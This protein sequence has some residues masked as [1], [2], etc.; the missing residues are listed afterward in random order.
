MLQAQFSSGSGPLLL[1]RSVDGAAPTPWG[2]KNDEPQ[3]ERISSISLVRPDGR[4][5]VMKP[6]L[7]G[8]RTPRISRRA[9]SNARALSGSESSQRPG[10]W[11]HQPGRWSRHRRRRT[12]SA[13][14]LRRNAALLADLY[15]IKCDWTLPISHGA[16]ADGD[17]PALV[18]QAVLS[19]I[20]A[21]STGEQIA[22]ARCRRFSTGRT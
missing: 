13:Q 9:P 16:L 18:F 1:R 8:G 3:G 2:S 10:H 19:T 22:Q 14:P 15:M 6:S 4:L 20:L 7:S 17:E 21:V 5:Q 11:L 12:G